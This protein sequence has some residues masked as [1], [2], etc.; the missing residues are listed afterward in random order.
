MRNILDQII[1]LIKKYDRISLFFH[2]H[3][4]F[5][6][7]G[8]VF[9]L[10]EYLRKKYPHKNVL[11]LG[12]EGI[13]K[14]YFDRFIEVKM[15]KTP[16]DEWI[17]KSLGIVCDTAN[18]ARVYE[19]KF[20]LC[21]KTIRIDHHPHDEKFCFLEWIERDRSS[22]CEMIGELLFYWDKKYIN[23]L[24]A[25][26][27]YIGILTD[28]NRFYYPSTTKSTLNL[29]AKLYKR[30]NDR[31]GIQELLCSKNI[32]DI[33]FQQYIY[34]IA[35]FDIVKHVA[36]LLI[37][38]LIFKKYKVE[39]NSMIWTMSN[40]KDIEIWTS[41][42]YEEEMKKWKGSIRSKKID[43]TPVAKKYNG[44]GHKLASGFVLENEK[45]FSKVIADLEKLIK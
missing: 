30:M 7:L 39:N 42:Y 40:I 27:L 45:D 44:G 41:I 12:L 32:E 28:T 31:M 36:S 37:P 26:C 24:V 8:S 6:T 33:K 21:K 23:S 25:S 16:S 11:I 1:K 2:S 18:S 34:S 19:Q 17:V 3:P 14:K 5:D 35:N 15:D 43:I 10:R 22:V 29:V 9:S 4:D 38:K 13:D 20:K